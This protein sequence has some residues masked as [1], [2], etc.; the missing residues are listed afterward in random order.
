M[1]GK[2]KARAILTLAREMNLD[3][4]QSWA[5]GDGAQDRWMLASVGNPAAV[6]PTPKLLRI[7]WKQGW[8]VLRTTHR[9]QQ[10]QKPLPHAERCA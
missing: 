1:F 9:V 2:A 10:T 3:L 6:N 4:R 5:Y 8:P 7:A